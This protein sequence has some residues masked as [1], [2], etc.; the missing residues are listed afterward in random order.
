[1]YYSMPIVEF[2]SKDLYVTLI[3]SLIEGNFFSLGRN[4]SAILKQILVQNY[5]LIE[6]Q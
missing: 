1:M 5:D 6:H 4:K 3:Q 2:Q